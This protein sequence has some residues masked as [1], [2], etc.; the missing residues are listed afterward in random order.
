MPR[1]S[2]AFL[3]VIALLT[4]ASGANSAPTLGERKEKIKSMETKV[5]PEAL[6]RKERSEAILRGEAVPLNKYLPV[7][8]TEK[9]AKR[10]TKEEVAYRAMALL[11]VAVKGEGLEQA[12]VE[13]I[14]RDYGLE[15]HF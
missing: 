15:N 5:S 10:R 9:E 11:I 8:E 13:N 4:L 7:I 3:F 6:R 14:V 12:I 2:A 1:Y